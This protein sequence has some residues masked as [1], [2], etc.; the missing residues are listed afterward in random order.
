MHTWSRGLGSALQKL[1]QWFESTRVLSWGDS[2]AGSAASRLHREG[3]GF[4]SL[5]PYNIVLAYDGGMPP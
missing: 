4:E 2:S 3:R 5:S 1:L